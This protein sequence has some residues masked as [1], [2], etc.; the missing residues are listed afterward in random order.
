[1]V[2]LDLRCGLPHGGVAGVL[3]DVAAG[4]VGVCLRVRV[5]KGETMVYKTELNDE[6]ATHLSHMWS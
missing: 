4:A 3:G 1:M 5:V 2:R 6:E